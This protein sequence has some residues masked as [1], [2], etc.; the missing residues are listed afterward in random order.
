MADEESKIKMAKV[1]EELTVRIVKD[2][3]RTTAFFRIARRA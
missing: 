2:K 1:D 3:G